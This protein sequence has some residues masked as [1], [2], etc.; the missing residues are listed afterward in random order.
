[1][2]AYPRSLSRRSAIPSVES[3]C[4]TDPTRLS[5]NPSRRIIAVDRLYGNQSRELF[6]VGTRGLAGLGDQYLPNPCSAAATP[7]FFAGLAPGGH[8]TRCDHLAF[9]VGQ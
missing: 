3:A 8:R 1:M 9:H 7:M 6:S 4:V 2:D 5:S